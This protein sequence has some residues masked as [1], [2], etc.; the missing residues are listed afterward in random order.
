MAAVVHKPQLN[1]QVDEG[2]TWPLLD[3]RYEFCAQFT[4]RERIGCCCRLGLGVCQF[5]PAVAAA[6]SVATTR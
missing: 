5:L 4:H 6:A 3:E 1:D 2:D